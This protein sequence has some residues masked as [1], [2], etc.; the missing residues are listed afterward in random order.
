M[1]FKNAKGAP[2]FESDFRVY[3]RNAPDNHINLNILSPNLDPMTYIIF[4]PYGELG[5]QPNLQIAD[6]RQRSNGRNN[7]TMLQHKVSQ[8]AV[9]Q[10]FNLLLH[11]GKL[12]QQ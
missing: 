4:Y 1:V 5:W 10:E 3:T 12:F 7:I 11:G 8:T 2:P 9:R 6:E